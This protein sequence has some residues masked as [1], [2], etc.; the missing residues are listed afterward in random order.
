MSIVP[1]KKVTLAGIAHE[2]NTVMQS[3]QELGVLHL[4]D[5]SPQPM[6]QAPSDPFKRNREAIAYLES[7]SIRQRALR[8]HP[9]HFDADKIIDQVIATKRKSQ[10]LTDAIEN[11]EKQLDLLKPWGNFKLPSPEDLKGLQLFFYVV[12]GSESGKSY[13]TIKKAALPHQIVNRD[14]SC[15]YVVVISDRQ[16]DLPGISPVAVPHLSASELEEHLDELLDQKDSNRT[17]RIGLT[18]YINLL[19]EH[20]G[21][22]L[23]DRDLNMA[24]CQTYDDSGLFALQ[25]WCPIGVIERVEVLAEQ[26]AL[27]IEIIEP[28]PDEE[29]PTQLQNNETWIGPGEDLVSFYNVPNYHT[30]DPSW[31]VYFSFIIFFGMIVNDA[32]YGFVMLGITFFFRGAM[33]KGGMRRLFRMMLALSLCTIAYGVLGGAYFGLTPPD[34]N[35]LSKLRWFDGLDLAN[36]NTMMWVSILIGCVHICFANVISAYNNRRSQKA[37]AHVGWIIAI[38]SAFAAWHVTASAFSIEGTGLTQVFYTGIAIGMG[39]VFLFN[40]PAPMTGKGLFQRFT[41]GLQGVFDITKAFSDVLS[42]LR[43]FALGLAGGYLAITFNNLAQDAND[44]GSFGFI[45]SILIIILGHTVNFALAIM[46]GVIHGLRLN[47]IEMY[48]WSIEG[49]GKVFSPFKKNVKASQEQPSATNR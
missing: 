10:E 8:R 19:R 21:E 9:Q 44:L 22:A 5:I 6:A 37:I 26:L 33:I 18:R 28:A 25:G 24:S 7:C 49:E 32:G 30:W 4:I 35:F 45:L 2:K 27:A 34:S 31:L 38:S 47:F 39:L 16:P 13:T 29:P 23:D 43:L 40:Q 46:S 20:L 17:H 42:Y 36:L 11:T 15:L 48:S 41:G 3:L 12:A 14:N 1:L